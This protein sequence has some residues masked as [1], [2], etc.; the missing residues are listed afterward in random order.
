[1]NTTNTNAADYFIN[2]SRVSWDVARQHAYACYQLQGYGCAEDFLEVWN[3]RFTS[4]EAR[5]MITDWTASLEEILE[6]SV[7]SE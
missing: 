6:I 7:D 2:G 4:E 3:M 5:K 1:M